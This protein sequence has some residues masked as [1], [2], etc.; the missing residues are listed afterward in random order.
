MDPLD[1]Q[2]G[3]GLSAG[4][5][6]RT[7]T[8][9]RVNGD[10]QVRFPSPEAPYHLFRLTGSATLASVFPLADSFVQFTDGG[11]VEARGGIGGDY[12]IG[13]FRASV[14]GWLTE[15]AANLDGGAEVGL[16]IDDH[17]VKLAGAKAVL[18]TV[19]AAACGEIPVI[20]VGGGLGVKWR[21][22][23]DRRASAAATS[24]PYSVARP[25]D[26]PPPPAGM[27]RAAQA[28]R[29]GSLVTV[30]EGRQVGRVRDPRRGGVRA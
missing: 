11:F 10:F 15:S 22:V 17:R 28:P 3:V 12:S 23:G 30:P 6:I 19:G 14:G 5:K 20:N 25:A 29:R 13:Y 27:A 18:S 26:A 16:L 9:L 8:L 4:P 7:Y 2:G 24:G 1:L 21:G